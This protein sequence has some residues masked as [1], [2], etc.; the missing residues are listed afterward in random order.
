MAKNKKKKQLQMPQYFSCP[1][2]GPVPYMRKMTKVDIEQFTDFMKDKAGRPE[3]AG[4]FD[5]NGQLIVPKEQQEFKPSPCY[6][7]QQGDILRCRFYQPLHDIVGEEDS[8]DS[9]WGCLIYIDHKT[10]AIRNLGDVEKN[11]LEIEV[12]KLQTDKLREELKMDPVDWERW[13]DEGIIVGEH[14]DEEED[15]EE[16]E[17]EPEEEEPE[18]EDKVGG[19]NVPD[20]AKPVDVEVK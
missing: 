13:E 5:T 11:E 19:E 9:E 16:G 17:E 15:G 1:F 12:L 10:A 18:P 8:E 4:Y 3:F 7:S 20:D 2:G 14:E 6:T